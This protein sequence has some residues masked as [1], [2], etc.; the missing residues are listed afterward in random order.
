METKLTTPAVKGIIIS[1]ILIVIGFVARL[2][3]LDAQSWFAW[4][5]YSLLLIA[6]II[7]CINY[8]NQNNNNV[9]FGNVFADGF[10]TT[11]VITCITLVFTV[12]LLLIMPEMKQRIFDIAK[13][14]AQQQGA[15]DQMIQT[16]QEMMT[17]FFWPLI[18]AGIIVGYLIIGA[19]ASLIGAAV[20]KKNPQDPF[21]Q[22]TM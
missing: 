19:I 3:N 16:Q 20:S 21:T 10:K 11:A 12:V 6:I 15:D 22:Q 1:L 17:K 18:I 7:S 14:Q 8:S 9:T 4:L 2:T 5:S 13:Q